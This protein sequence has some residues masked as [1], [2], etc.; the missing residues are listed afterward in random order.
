MGGA[1]VSDV[2]WIFPGNT[3]LL[4]P[5]RVVGLPQ[6]V[7]LAGEDRGAVQPSLEGDAAAQVRARALEQRCTAVMESRGA[8]QTGLGTAPGGMAALELNEAIPEEIWNQHEPILEEPEFAE[9]VRS[10][11]FSSAD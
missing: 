5:P 9:L 1:Q 11:L 2:N 8:G 7:E 4:S 3:R 10:R 6:P